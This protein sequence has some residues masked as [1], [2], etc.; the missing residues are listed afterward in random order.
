[1]GVVYAGFAFDSVLSPVIPIFLRYGPQLPDT[2][3]PNL[4]TRPYTFEGQ[5]HPSW[6][7]LH[8]NPGDQGRAGVDPGFGS[9]LLPPG[10]APPTAS[11][12]TGREQLP[13]PEQGVEYSSPLPPRRRIR[14]LGS[15]RCRVVHPSGCHPPVARFLSDP[16]RDPLV[17]RAHSPPK[18]LRCGLQPDSGQPAGSRPPGACSAPSPVRPGDGR[19][20]RPGYRYAA[21]AAGNA[22][23]IPKKAAV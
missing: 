6:S 13:A 18:P 8:F 23:F 20:L 11:R 1:M 15:G 9:S 16:V 12:R 19:I 5:P 17:E 14:R 4:L 10:W 3:G 21:S 2:V 7:S 22:L